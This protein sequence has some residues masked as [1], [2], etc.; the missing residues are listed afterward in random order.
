MF[1][2]QWIEVSFILRALEKLMRDYDVPLVTVDGK[3][4]VA[5]SQHAQHTMP[6]VEDLVSCLV[7]LDEV[8]KIIRLPKL[9]FRGAA[10]KNL[11]IVKIQATWR[12][13][14]T[15]REYERLKVLIGK[16]RVLQAFFRVQLEKRAARR[17]VAQRS[18]ATRDGF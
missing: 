4:L 15:Q 12:M 17:S 14:R 7:N 2:A 5:L 6:S 8:L 13:F 3:Q 18:Q 9:M 11:A 10:G 1:S 16:V